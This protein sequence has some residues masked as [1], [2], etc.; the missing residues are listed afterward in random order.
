[1]EITLAKDLFLDALGK[2]QGIVERRTVTPA[3]SHVYLKADDSGTVTMEATDMDLSLRTELRGSVHTAGEAVVSAR[4]VLEVVKELE[5]PEISLKVPDPRWMT[6]AAGNSTFKLV[7]LSPADFPPIPAAETAATVSLAVASLQEIIR[8]TAF[9]SSSEESRYAINGVL[10]EIVPAAGG[11]TVTAVGTDGHRLALY[12]PSIEGVSVESPLRCLVPR[13]TLMEVRR[14]FPADGMDVTIGIGDKGI[15]FAGGGTLLLSRVIQGQFPDY[16][17][18]VKVESTNRAAVDREPFIHAIRRVSVM[19]DEK[20]RQVRLDFSSGSVKI[21]S[22]HP[23]MGEAVEEMPIDYSGQEI[24]LAFNAIYVTEGLKAIDEPRATVALV[25][26][27][28]PCL[29]KGEGN[30]SFSYVVM[31]M[32]V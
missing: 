9:A 22:S 10:L 23:D 20:I 16:Q 5:G 18:V 28:K 26:D 4:K 32:R 12:H 21:S 17:G 19:G 7:C 8:K 15:S 6:I 13:R 27:F 2:V 14:L 11:A 29:I 25:G 31:P 24:S 1:M 30:E 3:L